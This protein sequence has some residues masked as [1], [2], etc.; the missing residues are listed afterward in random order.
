MLAEPSFDNLPAPGDAFEWRASAA[1]PMLVCR[2]LE[3]YA[4][5]LFTTREWQLGTAAADDRDDGWREVAEAMHVDVRHLARLH[6]VHDA[7]VVVLHRGGDAGAPRSLPDADVLVSDDPSRALAIQT[8]DCVPVLIADRRTG[9]VAAA[10]AG[11]RGLAARVP[12]AAVHALHESFGAGADDLV[13]AIG[14]SISA[15]NY[16]VDARVWSAFATAGVTDVQMARWF[17]PGT[18]AGHWQF[19]GWRSAVDQLHDAG[20]P[21][22]QIHVASLC[23]AAHQQ[24]CSYRRDGRGAGRIA[25]AIRMRA[26]S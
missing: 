4:P 11:W 23:T 10:H 26:G 5:H 16:E 12:A 3:S 9:S 14:P 6:Q 22:A 2:P 8:A 25:A 7:A 13:A 24:L 21:R 17:L 20:V 19:D 18:R 1:G 15:D